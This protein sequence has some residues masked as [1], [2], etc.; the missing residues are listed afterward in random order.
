MP[1]GTWW[2]GDPLPELPPL[3]TFSVCTTEDIQLIAQTTR[4]SKHMIAARIRQGNR[5]YI[6]FIEQT[7]VAYGWI[8]TREGGVTQFRL[9]F[10]ITH[11]NIYL[12]DFLTFPRWRGL[13]V[14]PHLLQAIIRQEQPTERFW[15]GYMPS[16]IASARGIRKAGFHIVSDFI[17]EENR[18]TGLTLFDTNERG[19]ESS[20]FFQLPVIAESHEKPFSNEQK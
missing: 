4:L 1:F 2:R 7:P 13:G 17:I 15:I 6:A 12:W 3:P 14:Y 8:A 19:Q 5:P 20:R 9:S 16:N 11:P 10:S 18:V